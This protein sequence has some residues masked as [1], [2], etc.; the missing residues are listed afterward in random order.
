MGADYCCYRSRDKDDA[1][2]ESEMLPQPKN[3]N[4]NRIKD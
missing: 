4:R 3:I 2:L 1:T